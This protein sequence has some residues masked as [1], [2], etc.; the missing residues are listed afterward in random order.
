MSTH[1]ST[2]DRRYRAPSSE[3][4]EQSSTRRVYTPLQT[5]WATFLGGPIA[6]GWLMRSNY[7]AFRQSERARSALL[8]GFLAHL[9]TTAASLLMPVQTLSLGVTVATMLAARHL[10]TT[11][12]GSHI[13]RILDA[14]G[15]AHSSWRSA[16]IGIAFGLLHM[17]IAIAVIA[18]IYP[19]MLRELLQAIGVS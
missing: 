13:E 6:A 12:Q 1:T 5:M 4:L 17:A 15:E 19:E 3:L 11:K 7:Q 9:V 18:A 16:G 8:I 2:V 10:V 14:D